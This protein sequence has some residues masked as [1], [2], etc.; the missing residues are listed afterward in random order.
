MKGVLLH[1]NARSHREV[2]LESVE[3]LRPWL[4]RD[5]ISWVHIVAPN[6][7]ELIALGAMFDLH[8]LAVS[9]IA[10]APQRP[11]W[12]SF[13]DH[14]VLLLQDLAPGLLACSQASI[15]CGERWL[16][17]FSEQESDSFEAVRERIRRG[18]GTIRAQ[19]SG[20]LCA[21]LAGSI[22]D[23]FPARVEE[24]LDAIDELADQVLEGARVALDD[25]HDVKQSLLMMRHAALPMRE[26][27]DHAA[28]DDDPRLDV[29]ATLLLQEVVHDLDHVRGMLDAAGGSA[30]AVGDLIIGM[31]SQRTSEVMSVMT[32]IATVFL[33]MTFLTGVWGMNFDT[34]EPGNMPELHWPFGYAFAW[35]AMFIS[36]GL[37]LGYLRHRGWLSVE[38]LSMRSKKRSRRADHGATSTMQS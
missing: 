16:L 25:L 19:S 11:R 9:N 27:L 8:P 12:Q 10:H 37:T 2:K 32:V 33:P 30:S 20:Y 26:A 35:G 6:E 23:A 31:V 18:L 24:H 15:V 21:A 7:R 29:H 4:A 17:S 28:R 34:S 36:A 38:R 1:Y 13:P 14:D 22:V 3:A 5:G